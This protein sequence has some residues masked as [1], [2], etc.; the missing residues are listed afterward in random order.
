MER[1]FQE[2]LFNWFDIAFEGQ[3][4]WW[5]TFDELVNQSDLNRDEWEN[6]QIIDVEE[7]S[8]GNTD[9]CQEEGINGFDEEDRSDASNVID[10]T[11]TF[12]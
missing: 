5:E 1:S 10:H 9:N 7:K 2:V 8:T 12:E 6:Q 11:T 3:D 4:K